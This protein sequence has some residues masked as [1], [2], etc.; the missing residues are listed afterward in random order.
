M[1]VGNVTPHHH[2]LA[3]G[4]KHTVDAI[5]VLVIGGFCANGINVCLG[6]ALPE[7]LSFVAVDVEIG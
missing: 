7:A 5:D 1:L 4:A 2:A 6:I 3:V